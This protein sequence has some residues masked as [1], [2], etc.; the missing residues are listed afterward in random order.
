MI[1]E[2]IEP[3]LIQQPDG[4]SK[5]GKFKYN[6]KWEF[7]SIQ[8]ITVDQLKSIYIKHEIYFYLFF[9]ISLL[10]EITVFPS[11]IKIIYSIFKYKM[12]LNYSTLLT[13]ILINTVFTIVLVYL[14]IVNIFK[15][16]PKNWKNFTFVTLFWVAWQLITPTVQGRYVLIVV[17][18][19]V[20]SAII[21]KFLS[22]ILEKAPIPI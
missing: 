14:I 2:E 21:A 9:S 22:N 1:V 12:I 6:I 3:I 19:R 11:I 18:T 16:S 5:L 10:F 8:S 17:S 7:W 4:S 20:I 13:G 15:K